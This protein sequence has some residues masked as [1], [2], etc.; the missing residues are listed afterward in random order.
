MKSKIGRAGGCELVSLAEPFPA[1]KLHKIELSD[2][3]CYNGIVGLLSCVVSTNNSTL[4]IYVLL[5][6]LVIWKVRTVEEAFFAAPKVIN[7]YYIPPNIAPT[8]VKPIA[9][10]APASM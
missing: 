7:Q 8:I 4:A 5:L 3:Y 10:P 6:Q 2:H 1:V 9:I